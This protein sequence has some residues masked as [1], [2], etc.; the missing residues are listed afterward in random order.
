MINFVV[1]DVRPFKEE[2][3][4]KGMICRFSIGVNIDGESLIELRELTLRK[5]REGK[6]YVSPPYRTFDTKNKQSKKS[7][8][9]YL[10]PAMNMD[11][12][13]QAMSNIISQVQERLG[14]IGKAES[15][16]KPKNA[17]ASVDP[18]SIVEDFC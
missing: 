5:T 12:R 15:S 7:Y 10:Y 3:Q 9:F 6:F 2:T 1:K 4:G 14:E 17:T 18:A 8:F 13:D 11:Q 16:N